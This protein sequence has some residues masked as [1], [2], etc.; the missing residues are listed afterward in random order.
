[1]EYIKYANWDRKELPENVCLLM[2]AQ[3]FKD[4]GKDAIGIPVAITP[5]GEEPQEQE[6]EEL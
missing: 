4:G 2:S 1:M 6:I 3:E 5:N